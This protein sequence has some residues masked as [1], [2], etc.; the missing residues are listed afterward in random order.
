M[1]LVV[2]VT[3]SRLLLLVGILNAAVGYGDFLIG[4]YS[5]A[6]IAGPSQIFFTAV[7]NMLVG[8]FSTEEQSLPSEGTTSTGS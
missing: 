7:V 5:P 1:V 6:N 3:K 8:Y 2:K 4:I